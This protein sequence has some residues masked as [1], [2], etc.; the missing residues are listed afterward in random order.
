MHTAA[1]NSVHDQE[2]EKITCRSPPPASSEKRRRSVIDTGVKINI[3]GR[4][5]FAL[6]AGAALH[7]LSFSLLLRLARFI[8]RME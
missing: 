5:V 3:F 4:H 2:V 6:C 8:C 7:L 1:I